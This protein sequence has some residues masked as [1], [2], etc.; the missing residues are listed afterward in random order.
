MRCGAKR[1]GHGRRLRE[2]D[3]AVPASAAGAAPS[4]EP[5]T[6]TRMRGQLHDLILVEVRRAR[7]GAVDAHRLTEDCA[8]GAAG[9]DVHRQ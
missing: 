2:R 3:A 9:V 4:L 8:R 7:A 5:R 6:G 1:G